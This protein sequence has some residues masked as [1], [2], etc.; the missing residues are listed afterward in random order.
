M[1]TVVMMV[2][3]NEPINKIQR[4][5]LDE[6]ENMQRRFERVGKMQVECMMLN[7][8]EDAV[9]G[10]WHLQKIKRY[11]IDGEDDLQARA[12]GTGPEHE[13]NEIKMEEEIRKL[14]KDADELA[15]KIIEANNQLLG[16]MRNNGS[17]AQKHLLDRQIK[18]MREYLDILEMRKKIC[19][20]ERDMMLEKKNCDSVNQ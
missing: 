18:A 5:Y 2:T 8:A 20:A 17:E 4:Y 12:A 15:G 1:A 16:D 9:V 13:N 6:M 7:D 11:D 10:G 14:E 3:T 19:K